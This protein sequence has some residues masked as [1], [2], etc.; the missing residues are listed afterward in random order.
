VPRAGLDAAA[1]T[2]CAA[3]VADELGLPQVTM[4]SV[5]TRLGVKA[6]SLYK[7]VGGQD[8]LV[9]RVAVQAYVELG[10]ALRDAL[11][12]RSGRDALA[13]SAWTVRRWVRD[14]PGRYAAVSRAGGVAPGREPATGGAADLADPRDEALEQAVGRVLDSLAAA[15]AGYAPPAEETVH[16]MRLLR[17]LFEG[18]ALLEAAGGFQL[19]TDVDATFE[20]MIDFVDRG[21]RRPPGPDPAQSVR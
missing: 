7:H 19:A 18:F 8:D 1:V 12:G 5:A 17:T 4:A 15:V 3:D 21:L 11:Q 13:A 10:D 2:A 20:W 16:A 14:H 9:R 6:P